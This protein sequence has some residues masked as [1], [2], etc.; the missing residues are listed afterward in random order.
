VAGRHVP[1]VPLSYSCRA[2][3]HILCIHPSLNATTPSRRQEECASDGEGNVCATAAERATNSGP[4]VFLYAVPCRTRLHVCCVAYRRDVQLPTCL[5]AIPI[6]PVYSSAAS[7]P[8]L[9]LHNFFG[10][11]RRSWNALDETSGSQDQKQTLPQVPRVHGQQ[12]LPVEFDT[13]GLP[14]LKSTFVHPYLTILWEEGNNPTNDTYCVV[15]SYYISSDCLS[16]VILSILTLLCA[17]HI[18]CIVPLTSLCRR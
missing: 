10:R 4:R 3:C 2:A 17:I 13:N 15:L 8:R 9:D 1:P 7:H 11:V 18:Y 6:K 14:T 5:E 16:C 12:W